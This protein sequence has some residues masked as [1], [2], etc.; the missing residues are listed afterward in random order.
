MFHLLFRL[1]AIY[2]VTKFAI[3]TGKILVQGADIYG[4]IFPSKPDPRIR[5]KKI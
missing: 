1:T 3:N 2:Y 5:Q 4:K